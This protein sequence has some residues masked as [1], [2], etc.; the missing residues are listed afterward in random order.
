MGQTLQY[1]P[2]STGA[3]LS[4]AANRS[5]KKINKTCVKRMKRSDKT[6][7]EKLRY[8]WYYL[9]PGQTSMTEQL[10]GDQT[11]TE[12]LLGSGEAA[13]PVAADRPLLSTFIDLSVFYKLVDKSEWQTTRQIFIH[14]H[15]FLP[16]VLTTTNRST[17]NSITL[18]IDNGSDVAATIL[19][20]LRSVSCTYKHDDSITVEQSW[21]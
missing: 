11:Q 3:V 9:T 20:T 21:K 2:G 6:L 14:N 17:L 4:S 19:V 15:S 1:L 13:S 5:C 16:S 8:L 10:S 12:D 18:V 7:C